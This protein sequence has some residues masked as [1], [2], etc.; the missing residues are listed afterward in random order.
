[1]LILR[2]QSDMGCGG[3]QLGSLIHFG[4]GL[5]QRWK[6]CATQNQSFS[7]NHKT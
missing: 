3:L 7:A 6:R 4:R 5:S 1:M 2:Q